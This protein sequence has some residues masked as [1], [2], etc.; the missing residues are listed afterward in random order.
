MFTSLRAEISHVLT[1]NM[2]TSDGDLCSQGMCLFT[3]LIAAK[4]SGIAQLR[5]KKT[6][7]SGILAVSR[8]RV[9]D[10]ERNVQLTFLVSKTDICGFPKHAAKTKSTG[11]AFLWFLQG[12]YC[13]SIIF[14][15]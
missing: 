7:E 13:S 10:L 4:G 1:K 12:I 5:Y 6:R 9:G 11:V 15:L 2:G 3:I 8:A 14:T